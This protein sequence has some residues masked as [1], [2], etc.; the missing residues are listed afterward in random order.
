V[1]GP[2]DASNVIEL[3]RIQYERYAKTVSQSSV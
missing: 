2:E 3:F 1:F